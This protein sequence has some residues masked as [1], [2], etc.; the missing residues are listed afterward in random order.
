MMTSKIPKQAATRKQLDAAEKFLFQIE[1]KAEK[2]RQQLEEKKRQKELQQQKRAEAKRKREEAK[3]KKAEAAKQKKELAE[4]KKKLQEQD[5][6]DLMNI[7]KVN[8]DCPF[9]ADAKCPLFS[10]TGAT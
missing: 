1:R 9:S 3:R 5:D 2:K 4:Q 7:L 10:G 6:L 8:L